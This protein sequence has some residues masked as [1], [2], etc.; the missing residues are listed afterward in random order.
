MPGRG[1]FRVPTGTAAVTSGKVSRKALDERVRTMLKFVMRAS[2]KQVAEDPYP[3]D[4]E[5]DR[6]LNRRLATES[7]VLL[8]NDEKVLPLANDGG[9][10]A[11]IGPN[12]KMAAVCGGG[13]ASLQPHYTVTPFEAIQKQVSPGTRLYYEVGAYA[14]LLHPLFDRRNITC[15]S[16]QPGAMIRFYND[17][18]YVEGRQCLAQVTAPDTHIQLMDYTNPALN[19]TYYATLTATFVPEI[20]G[21]YDFGLVVYG[22]ANLY[23]DDELVIDNT[24]NQRHGGLFFSKG[25]VEELGHFG[26]EARRP[27]N[28]RVEFGNAS[29][30]KIKE[31]YTSSFAG[32]ALRLGGCLRL[33]PDQSIQRAVELAKKCKHTIIIAGLN[34]CLFLSTFLMISA[35]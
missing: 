12:A 2:Q 20:S 33:D 31:K 9:D 4:T 18:H 21:I 14:H 32:G 22:T 29:T 34:V 26:M 25:T 16:G 10:I 19:H 35:S 23:I 28:L 3:R 17:P 8:K 15:G 13:S 7:I 27:Y 5:N 1:R 11:V 30:S 6:E 24:T